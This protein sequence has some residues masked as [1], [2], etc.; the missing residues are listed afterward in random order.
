MNRQ[1]VVYHLHSDY[2]LLDSTTKFKD[3]V[4]MAAQLGQTALASTEHG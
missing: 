4:E 3:Y 2:S 1:Y